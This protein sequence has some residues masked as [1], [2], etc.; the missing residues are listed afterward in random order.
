MTRVQAHRILREAYATAEIHGAH[1]ELGTHTMRKT[2]AS[3]MWE[4]HDGNI[5]KVQNA[6]GHASPASTVAYLS[7][8]D[9]EQHDAVYTA[10]GDPYHGTQG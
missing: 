4:A 6:L 10:F 7:F 9:E 5:W 2:F 8:N 1:G 3:K